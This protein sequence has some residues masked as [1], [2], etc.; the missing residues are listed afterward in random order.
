M[1]EHEKKYPQITQIP[2][3]KISHEEAQKA[4]ENFSVPSNSF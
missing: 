4:Q 1:T 2:Q 3:I